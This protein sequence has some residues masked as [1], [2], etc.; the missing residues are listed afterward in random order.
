MSL[1]TVYVENFF[2]I[3]AKFI[4]ECGK[5]SLI[6]QSE[7]IT[8]N[9]YVKLKK[10]ST[11]GFRCEDIRQA[12]DVYS[13]LTAHVRDVRSY[14]SR[15]CHHRSSSIYYLTLCGNRHTAVPFDYQI[16]SPGVL[17]LVI[18]I[19]RRLLSRRRDGRLLRTHSYTVTSI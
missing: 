15:T 13:R 12:Q 7:S 11:T 1:S 10:P 18:R 3:N 2:R 14:R 4:C 19:H 6:L 5:L 17:R 8:S 9:F 16:Q